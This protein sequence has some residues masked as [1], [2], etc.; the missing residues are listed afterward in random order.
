MVVGH[1]EFST[2]F[3]R[4][5][6]HVAKDELEEDLLQ[7]VMTTT[8]EE[9]LSP[10]CL[11]DVAKYFCLVEEEA[12]FQDLEQ[13][14]K[15]ETSSVLLKQLPS[16][17]QYVFLN[18]DRETPVIICDKLS[19]DETQRLVATL[20][21]YQS[22]IGYSLKDLK[23]ISLSL[24]THHIPMEQEHKPVH[25]H[26]RLLSNAM[27]EVVKNEVLKLLKVVVIYPISDSEWVSLVQVVL[28]KGGMTTHSSA[29][30]HRLA[31]VYRLPE[32]QQSYSERSLPATLH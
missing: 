17:M 6:N 10:P 30:C 9:E 20:E 27:R 25:E 32:T 11:D 13:E 18:G 22:V 2:S 21:K 14:V 7:Q 5:V 16:E 28:K 8:L 15:P 24:C 1:Q 3:A 19:N 12:E 29:D 4:A 23:G 31:N 26:Q